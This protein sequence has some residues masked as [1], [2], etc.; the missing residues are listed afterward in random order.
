MEIQEEG[1]RRANLERELRANRPEP[2][3][4]FV[5]SLAA[6]IRESSAPAPARRVRASRRPAFRLRLAPALGFTILCLVAAGAFGGAA[7]ATGGGKHSD[8]KAEH[9][10]GKG[11]NHNGKRDDNDDDDADEDQYDK[12]VVICHHPNGND[13]HTIRVSKKAAAKHIANHGDTLGPCPNNRT[14]ATATATTTTTTARARTTT[15]RARTARTTTTTRAR[16]R[17]RTARTTT[18]RA[19]ARTARTTTI[20][21]S[22]PPSPLATERARGAGPPRRRSR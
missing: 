15:T 1:S 12:K 17:A 6:E 19:R 18:A 9:D 13:P 2:S 11:D 3:A 21:S 14:A 10:N 22:P 4:D 16:A 7:I 8:D 20:R 5:K